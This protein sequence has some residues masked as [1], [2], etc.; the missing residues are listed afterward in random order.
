MECESHLVD[1]RRWRIWVA[2]RN[3]LRFLWI[4]GKANKPRDDILRNM[5]RKTQWATYRSKTVTGIK[6]VFGSFGIKL[7][8]PIHSQWNI[9]ITQVLRNRSKSMEPPVLYKPFDARPTCL[10]CNCSRWGFEPPATRRSSC[11]LRVC[12][13]M[14]LLP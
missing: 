1:V 7:N 10:L 8:S 4:F 14:V 11:Q 2:H 12:V 5:I 3:L 13:T 9:N 6:R